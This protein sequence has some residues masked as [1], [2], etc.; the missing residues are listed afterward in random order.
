MAHNAFDE[1]LPDNAATNEAENV[2]SVLLGCAHDRIEQ[3]GNEFIK[4]ERDNIR[5]DEDN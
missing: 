4:T 3:N 2:G 1:R 5:A